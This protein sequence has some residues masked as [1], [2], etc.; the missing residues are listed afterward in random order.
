MLFHGLGGSRTDR[1]H[2][3]GCRSTRSPRPSSSPRAT[4]RSPSTRAATGSRRGSSRSTGRARSR[5]CGS[6]SAGSP[7]SRAST[8]ADRRFGLLVRRRR[9]L[10]RDGR[11]RPVRGDR[12]GDHVDR[13]L[14]RAPAPGP[15]ALG[16]RARLL[17]VDRRPAPHPGSS[18]RSTTRS[19][20]RTSPLFMRSPTNDRRGRSSA[21]SG[22]RRSSCRADATSPSTST[23]RSRRTRA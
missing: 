22:C 9:D 1:E 12:A 10:A 7:R 18:R 15:R 13:P 19:R 5:T 11:G 14:L 3:S 21:T 17:A 16:R 20:A 2:R 8:S 23:R 4:P 6:S